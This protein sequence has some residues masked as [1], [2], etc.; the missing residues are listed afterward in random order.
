MDW[1]RLAIDGFL[2]AILIAATWTDVAKGKV[3]NALTYSAI[4]AGLVVNTFVEPAGIG[5]SDSLL[6][7]ATGF[8]PM[9]LIYLGGGLGGGDVKLMGAVGAFVGPQPAL[10]TLL[11]SCIVGALLCLVILLWKEGAPGLVA[12]WLDRKRPAGEPDG[13]EAHRF[14]FALAIL[15]GA[16]WT[17]TEVHSGKTLLD[18]LSS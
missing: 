1:G 4:L 6:G 12:R 8:A 16:A 10:F 17:L 14:P 18:L 2:L 3:Y 13:F 9:F 15:V 11:Y 7:F 5:W